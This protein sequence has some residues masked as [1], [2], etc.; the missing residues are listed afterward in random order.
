MVYKKEQK[1]PTYTSKKRIETVKFDAADRKEFIQGFGKRKA[2]RKVKG[3][4]RATRE[5]REKHLSE[6]NSI[7]NH[8]SAELR[9]ADRAVREIAG[10]H[11]ERASPESSD[12]EEGIKAISTTYAEVVPKADTFGNVTVT[13]TTW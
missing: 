4:E 3:K 11:A 5:A 8:M 6:R 13:T 2:A 9:R 1:T 12:D 7:R 10:E